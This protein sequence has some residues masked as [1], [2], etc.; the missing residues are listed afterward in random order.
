[1]LSHLLFRYIEKLEDDADLTDEQEKELKEK[2]KLSIHL[3]M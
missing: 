2:H 1:M 3:N